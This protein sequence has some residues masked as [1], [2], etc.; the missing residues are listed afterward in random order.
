MEL[1]QGGDL[2]IGVSPSA[3]VDIV[4]AAGQVALEVGRVTGQPN[5]KSSDIY[6]FMDSN[7]AAAGLNYY[8]ASHVVLAQGGGNVG[9]GVGLSPSVRFHVEGDTRIQGAESG[10][11]LLEIY[12]DQGDD[13]NDRWKFLAS[14]GATFSLEHFGT[15]TWAGVFAATP[16]TPLFQLFVRPTLAGTANVIWQAANSGLYA[17]SS[18]I[19]H[20]TNVR[21]LTDDLGLS[22]VQKLRPVLFNSLCEDDPKDQE[23]LGFIAE[24]IDDLGVSPLVT[25]GEE[26]VV[27]SVQYD[28][29]TAVLV[30]AMQEMDAR[31]SKLEAM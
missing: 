15:G 26:G 14:I 28:R 3:K 20:K 13:N 27:E 5:I 4:P 25:Y 21:D 11:G 31:V 7:G 12:A 6:L 8:T 16:A 18:S 2:G 24:D 1:T 10:G 30:K 29:I 22:L 17:V 23:F 9:I 19:R